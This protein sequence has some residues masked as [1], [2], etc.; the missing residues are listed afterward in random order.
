MTT[1][2]TD[3]AVRILTKTI[4]KLSAQ[5]AEADYQAGIRA[6]VI[7]DLMEELDE[8]RA[9][10]GAAER[11][12][13]EQSERVVSLDADIAIANMRARMSMAQ[14]RMDDALA[15]LDSDNSAVDRVD[16]AR[17]ILRGEA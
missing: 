9:S 6:S 14:N 3:A 5:L 4:R 10:R 16:D 12:W 7:A 1:E 17:R 13:I 8:E 2:N 11:A 15:A